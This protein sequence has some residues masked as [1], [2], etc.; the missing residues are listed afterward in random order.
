MAKSLG[1]TREVSLIRNLLDYLNEDFYIPFTNE[2]L[3][4]ISENKIALKYT[5]DFLYNDWMDVR[6]Y[7]TLKQL[8]ILFESIQTENDFERYEQ[9]FFKYSWSFQAVDKEILKRVR[10]AAIKLLKWKREIGPKIYYQPF[11]FNNSI[12]D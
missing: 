5:L 11:I 4:S 6:K 10:D 1:C 8:A 7:L 9:I 12:T 2:I 3:T